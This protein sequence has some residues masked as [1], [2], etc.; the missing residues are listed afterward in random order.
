MVRASDI[1]LEG[2]EYL[3]SVGA[4][5]T[6]QPP[7]LWTQADED[8]FSRLIP[9]LAAQVRTVESV[10]YL[11]STLDDG[12]EGFLLTIDDGQGNAIRQIGRFSP[13]ERGEVERQTNWLT[14]C[15]VFLVQAQSRK[16]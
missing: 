9:Q 7:N 15:T 3:E 4:G 12:E 2:K 14:T 16:F 10:Q 5:V 13:G 1:Q 6:G 8:N 11:K